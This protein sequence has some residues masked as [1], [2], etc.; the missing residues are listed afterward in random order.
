M[1]E[2]TEVMTAKALELIA[3]KDPEEEWTFTERLV[4][5]SLARSALDMLL[6]QQDRRKEK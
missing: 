3:E 6:Q 2:R 4:V 1:P 5:V